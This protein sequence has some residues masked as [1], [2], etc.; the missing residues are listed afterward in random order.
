MNELA[1]QDYE[2]HAVLG[3]FASDLEQRLGNCI[4][5]DQRVREA[6]DF[7]LRRSASISGCDGI[8]AVASQ[9]VRSGGNASI[10]ALATMTG[11]SMRQVERRS[12]HEVGTPPKL[13][14]RIARFEAAL[15]T[16]ARSTT[17]SWTD[18]AHEFGY[19]DQMH[20]IHDF[21]DF[22]GETPTKMLGQVEVIFREHLDA[23]R[24]DRLSTN[25]RRSD[26]LIL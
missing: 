13:Y 3:V 16:K 5:F 17:K 15:D 25:S 2:A 11:L 4:S 9:I 1:D 19:Y 8:T 10:P 26:R 22:T 21:E 7:L 6:N 23:I 18:V 14:A 24:S 20:M 12:L